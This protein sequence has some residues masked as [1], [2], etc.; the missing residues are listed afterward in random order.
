MIIRSSDFV[1]SLKLLLAS[2]RIGFRWSSTTVIKGL[3]IYMSEDRWV[4]TDNQEKAA[5]IDNY[6]RP[7][8]KKL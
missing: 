6:L 8:S 1:L 3:V 4:T 7:K 2:S 5:T